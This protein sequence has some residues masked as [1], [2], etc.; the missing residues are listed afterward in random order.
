MASALYKTPYEAGKTEGK[1]EGKVEGKS[2]ILVKLLTKKFGVLP[3]DILSK[4]SKADAYYL[5]LIAEG[6][7]DFQSLDD[8]LKYLPQ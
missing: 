6:V 3:I 7:L 1:I 8:V 4:I 5:D 2:E